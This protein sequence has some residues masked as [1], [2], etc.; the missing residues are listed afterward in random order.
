MTKDSDA[1]EATQVNTIWYNLQNKLRWLCH[2]EE[3]W[4][5]IEK[6]RAADADTI[7]RQAAEN[8][9]LREVLERIQGYASCQGKTAVSLDHALQQIWNACQTKETSHDR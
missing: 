4:P 7:E 2:Y 8:D 5:L 9:R 3:L 6:A 1:L